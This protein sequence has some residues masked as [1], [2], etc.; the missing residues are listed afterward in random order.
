M[1]ALVCGQLRCD[2]AFYNRM[3]IPKDKENKPDEGKMAQYG[4]ERFKGKD[5]YCPAGWAVGSTHLER[6]HK[7]FCPAAY[8]TLTDSRQEFRTEDLIAETIA[9][10][11]KFEGLYIGQNCTPTDFNQNFRKMIMDCH[12]A[13]QKTGGG[14]RPVTYKFD[15]ELNQGEN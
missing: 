15:P 12:W 6:L 8:Q 7:E 13:V 9:R 5:A 14:P 11:V 10:N 1:K 2:E 3:I 4:Y